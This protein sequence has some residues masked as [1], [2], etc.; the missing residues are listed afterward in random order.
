MS[1]GGKKSNTLRWVSSAA[2]SIQR[3]HNIFIDAYEPLKPSNKRTPFV[4][5]QQGELMNH[6]LKLLLRLASA[7]LIV[8]VCIR[9]FSLKASPPFLSLFYD[10]ESELITDPKQ[11]PLRTRFTVRP[12]LCFIRCR[13]LVT[14]RHCV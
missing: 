12:G 10:A 11:K 3:H 13:C 5:A 1:R 8:F 7:G 6:P 14:R 9:I 2:G 4:S